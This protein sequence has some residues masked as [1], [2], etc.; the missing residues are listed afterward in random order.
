MKFKKLAEDDKER[1][2]TASANILAPNE[3]QKMEN[4]I[5]LKISKICY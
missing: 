2:E 4:H 3:L 1:F 5:D